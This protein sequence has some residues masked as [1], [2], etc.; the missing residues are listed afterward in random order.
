M[1]SIAKYFNMYNENIKKEYY[2]M[3]TSYEKGAKKKN[4]GRMG[5]GMGGFIFAT[6]KLEV[7]FQFNCRY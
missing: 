4:Y 7:I 1:Q 3:F 2:K 6:L 5:R